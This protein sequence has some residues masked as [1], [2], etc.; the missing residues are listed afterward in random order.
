MPIY[1]LFIMN[2]N[3]ILVVEIESIDHFGRGI[4][5]HDNIPI[6]VFKNFN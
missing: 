6:F 5:K 2:V 4:V 3:D 1:W